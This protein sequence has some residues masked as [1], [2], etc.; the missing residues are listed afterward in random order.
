[1]MMMMVRKSAAMRAAAAATRAV[2]TTTHTPVDALAAR[3]AGISVLSGDS[4]RTVS[5]KATPAYVALH[6][7]LSACGGNS[8]QG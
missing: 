8:N 6:P 3:A 4:R 2:L 1:M 5:A 7:S